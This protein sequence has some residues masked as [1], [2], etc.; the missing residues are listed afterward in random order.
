L[1]NTSANPTTNHQKKPRQ[2]SG[3]REILEIQVDPGNEE[4]QTLKGST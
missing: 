4:M 2:G 3:A 1:T